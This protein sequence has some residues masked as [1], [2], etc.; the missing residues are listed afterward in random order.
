MEPVWSRL[1]GQ[2]RTAFVLSGGGALG[3]IQV[4]M[5][6]ALTEAGIRPDIVIG[7]SVGSINGAGY[8]ADPTPR[9]VTR[10]ERIW[11]RV[12]NGD[13]ALMPGGLIPLAVQFARKG[14]SLHD[15]GPLEALIRSELPVDTFEGLKVP[16]QCVATDLD[17]SAEHWFHSGELMPA[18]MASAALPS[19]YPARQ[20]DGRFFIDGGVLNE[21]HTQRAVELGASELYVLHV[22]HLDN[23]TVDVQRP[24]DAA[25]RAYWTTRRHRFAEDLRRVPTHC[26]V[27]RLPAGSVP[28]TRFDDFSRAPDLI[29]IARA[30][31][32]AHLRA[33]PDGR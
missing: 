4:G 19:V 5:L 29:E 32:A 17:R 1:P 7:C 22:G 23:R 20:I 10:L 27:H 6:K 30:A 26:R 8:A 9:G 18:I 14:D 31:T 33:G 28:K 3:A 25:L 11:R 21:I 13:P 12:A 15:P 16:F 2:R 24:F